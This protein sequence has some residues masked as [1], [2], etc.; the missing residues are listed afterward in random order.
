MK[1]NKIL[2]T[3][4]IQLFC[5]LLSYAFA[6]LLL[7]NFSAIMAFIFVMGAK[8][9]YNYHVLLIAFIVLLFLATIYKKNLVK[10]SIAISLLVPILSPVLILL[11]SII[12]Y[13]KKNFFWLSQMIAGYAL[14]ISISLL[15]LSNISRLS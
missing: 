13:N 3:V 9:F 11:N 14:I 1:D 15:Y 2:L 6:R 10:T 12:L 7:L 4:I 5:I 8:D